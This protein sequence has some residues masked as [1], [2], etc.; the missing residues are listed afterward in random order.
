VPKV[1]DHDQRRDEVAA[2]AAGV[3]VVA[4]I[5]SSTIR[6]VAAAGGW[7]T[8][9]VTHYFANKDELLM[10]T[11]AMS[12]A[13][14]TRAIEAAQEAGVD[15]LRAIVEQIL[16][17]DSERSGRW[18]LWLAFWGRA[19]GSDELAA[20][21]RDRQEELVARLGSVLERRGHGGE[22]SEGKLEARRLVA[23]LD[24]V[25]VQA[26]FA[27]DQ[28]PPDRQLAHFADLLS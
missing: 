19:I 5:D 16:P 15:E 18:R 23:L 24:G 28:W 2:V 12:V 20:V 4:G 14:S 3:L 10:H 27:P 8:T 7:S 11:L 1:V 9:M 26:T 17:L 25:S 22:P 13:A 6:D 21:Q